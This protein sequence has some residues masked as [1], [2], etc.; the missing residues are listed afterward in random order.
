MVALP[1]W[2]IPQTQPKIDLKC[3]SVTNL[4][5]TVLFSQVKSI[6]FLFKCDHANKTLIRYNKILLYTIHVW[7]WMAENFAN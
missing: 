3:F 5:K 2:N 6:I 7:S 1:A 4:V